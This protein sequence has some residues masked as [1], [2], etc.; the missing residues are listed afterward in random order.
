MTPNTIATPDILRAEPPEAGVTGR[1]IRITTALAVAFVAAVAAV[2]LS[3]VRARQLREPDRSVY[4]LPVL[5]L[6]P[7]PAPMSSGAVSAPR[8]PPV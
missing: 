6:G 1:L 5:C 7:S 2:A 4:R 3:L 8:K